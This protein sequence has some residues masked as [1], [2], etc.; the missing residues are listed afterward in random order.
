MPLVVYSPGIDAQ[1]AVTTLFS[2]IDKKNWVYQ[3]NF[4]RWRH[5]SRGPRESLKINQEIGQTIYDIYTLHK[6]V[7]VVI[8]NL[9]FL[10]DS[11]IDGGAVDGVDAAWESFD[12]FDMELLGLETLSARVESLRKRVRQLEA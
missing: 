10:A 9:D 1:T 2:A 5:R 6:R 12:E 3:P 4:V 8:D 11:I 7:N